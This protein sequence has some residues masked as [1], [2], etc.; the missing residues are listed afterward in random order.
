MLIVLN[1]LNIFFWK[2]NLFMRCINASDVSRSCRSGS[3][4]GCISSMIRNVITCYLTLACTIINIASHFEKYLAK[5]GKIIQ[6]FFTFSAQMNKLY[7]PLL[8][9]YLITHNF[10]FVTFPCV[11]QGQWRA[12]PNYHDLRIHSLWKLKFYRNVIQY[13]SYLL[14]CEVKYKRVHFQNDPEVLHLAQTL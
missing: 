3:R 14:L 13:W 4:S 1:S 5:N 7:S 6:T 11:D 9:L 2:M 12:F 10:Q 8:K